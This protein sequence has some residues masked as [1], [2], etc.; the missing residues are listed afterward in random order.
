MGTIFMKTYRVNVVIQNAL[1]GIRMVRADFKTQPSVDRRFR[2]VPA[3]FCCSKQW[4]LPVNGRNRRSTG[5]WVLKP[6]LS[7][8]Y[9]LNIYKQFTLNTTRSTMTMRMM[10]L[11]MWR[12]RRVGGRRRIGKWILTNLCLFVCVF[13]SLFFNRRNIVE[14]YQI[15]NLFV[16]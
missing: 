14:S 7:N 10:L 4:Q 5:G 15:V 16:G 9:L 6:P 13:S 3:G 8:V 11:I 1:K 2:P 12:R